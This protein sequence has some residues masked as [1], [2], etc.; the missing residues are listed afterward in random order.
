MWLSARQ[1]IVL[2]FVLVVGACSTSGGDPRAAHQHAL[3]Q[4]LLAPCCWRQ[5][6]DDHESP[7]A[8]KLR[9]EIHERLAADEPVASIERDLVERYGERIRALPEH[10]DPRWIIGAAAASVSMLSL[11]AIAVVVRRRRVR[12]TAL[13][14]AA[15]VADDAY[16]DRLDDELLAID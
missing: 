2:A 7:V 3:E 10:G 11:I 6:L 9:A 4:R 8:S 14:L 12:P 5:T 1:V 16:A 13:P 15:P